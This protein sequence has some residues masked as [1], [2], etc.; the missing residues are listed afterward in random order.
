MNEKIFESSILLLL[1]NNT[2]IQNTIPYKIYDYLVSE[3]QIIT[4]GDYVNVDV[5]NLLKKYKRRNRVA[6]ND[7]ESIRNYITQSF[8]DFNNNNLKNISLDYSEIKFSKL[9][10]ILFEII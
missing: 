10:D 5:E 1:L 6:Y 4:L 3:K 7:K 9:K 2:K 8:H